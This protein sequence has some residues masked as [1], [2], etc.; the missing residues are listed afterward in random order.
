MWNGLIWLRTE[1]SGGQGF[2]KII[3]IIKLRQMLA[4]ELSGEGR[5]HEQQDGVASNAFCYYTLTHPRL[6]LRV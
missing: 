2:H 4:E 3:N 1:A 6:T 5:L